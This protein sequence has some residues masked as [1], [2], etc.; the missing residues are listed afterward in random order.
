MEEQPT[1]TRDSNLWALLIGIDEYLHVTDLR[2]CV[3]DV[4]AMRVWLMS[5]LEV[6]E[7]HIRVLTDQE[8]TRANILQAFQEFLID[9]PAIERG[10]QILFHYSGHGSQMP[11]PLSMEPD[12]LNETLVAHDSR[13]PDVYD[14]PDKEFRISDCEL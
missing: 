14:I 5:Q 1:I 9:N 10:D 4:E 12:G 13:S 2:G 11:D 8:A 6:P 3:N 7:D